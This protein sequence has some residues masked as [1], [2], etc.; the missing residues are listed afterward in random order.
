MKNEHLRKYQ[1]YL[2]NKFDLMHI[3]SQ[4]YINEVSRYC[5]N[6]DAPTVLP[7]IRMTTI[8]SSTS[9]SSIEVSPPVSS[10]DH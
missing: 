1:Q 2:L 10:T 8:I 7:L 5:P 6:R 3:L 4:Y 9:A